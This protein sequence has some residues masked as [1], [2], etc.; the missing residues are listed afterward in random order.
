MTLNAIELAYHR[1]HHPDHRQW[2]RHNFRR[3]LAELERDPFYRP[4]LKE[5]VRRWRD[6]LAKLEQDPLYP[7]DLKELIPRRRDHIPNAVQYCRKFILDQERQRLGIQFEDAQGLDDVRKWGCESNVMEWP[8]KDV[9]AALGIDRKGRKR[10][11]YQTK[12]R[13]LTARQVEAA[14][15]VADNQGSIKTAA[16]ALGIPRDRL[17]SRYS[18]AM[19]KL[20]KTSLKK[21]KTTRL[22]KDRRGSVTVS[23]DRRREEEK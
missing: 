6:H 8:L 16:A 4:V 18:K 22:P 14:E 17:K 1:Q 9:A 7:P 2:Q 19:K 21:P 12:P 13:P 11:P 23:K 5:L 3:T 10:G 20:G 15:R